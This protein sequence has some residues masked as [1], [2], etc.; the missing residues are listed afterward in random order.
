MKTVAVIEARMASTRLP[1]KVL[2][3]ILGRPMLALLIERVS[4]A[5]LVHQIVVATTTNPGDDA[6]QALAETLGVGCYR[7]SE[8]DVLNRVL[9]AAQKFSAD[10]IVEI[11]GD[12]PLT[13]PGVIDSVISAF[14]AHTCDYASNIMKRTFPRG[15]DVQVFP[16]RVLEEVARLTDDPVDHEHVSLYMYEHPDR[17]SL[18]NVE[19]TLDPAW[20]DLRLTVDTAE[21]LQL[22]TEIFARLYPGKALFSLEEVIRLL[23]GDPQL[24]EI[25]AHISQKKVR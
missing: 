20:W 15:L 2:R 6:I 25:N 7:G 18:L 10:L 5:S 12:C 23:T 3:P 14:Q 17:F 13:D 19:S 22:V 1:G 8:E 11:T 9:E 21:D 16:T 4:A 24:L